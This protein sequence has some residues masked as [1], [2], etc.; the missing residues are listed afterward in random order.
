[1]LTDYAG[2]SRAAP[3]LPAL[4]GQ[5]WCFSVKIEHAV[6]AVRPCPE[7]FGTSMLARRVS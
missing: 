6:R 2:R 3:Q 1:M 7:A 5:S 4:I